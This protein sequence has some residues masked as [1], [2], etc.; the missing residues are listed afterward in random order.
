MSG[1]GTGG[2]EKKRMH[3]EQRRGDGGRDGGFLN[4]TS[5]PRVR[6]QHQHLILWSP[7]AL[8]HTSCT[9]KRMKP[10]QKS[11]VDFDD[12]LFPMILFSC[13]KGSHCCCS[14]RLYQILTVIVRRLFTSCSLFEIV[15]PPQTHRR[16]SVL[17]LAHFGSHLCKQKDKSSTLIA[18]PCLCSTG[19]QI[20]LRCVRGVEYSLIYILL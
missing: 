1:W 16:L 3:R 6:T 9:Y 5:D 8:S 20:K 17:Y 7:Q 18:E 13:R 19:M 4:H 10:A 15:I 14:V 11:E 12:C 2:R